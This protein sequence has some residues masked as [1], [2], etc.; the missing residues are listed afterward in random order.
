MAPKKTEVTIGGRSLAFSN[1][2][3]V[4]WPRDGYTKGQL[5]EYYRGVARWIIP[6]LRNRP[7]TLQRWPDGIDGQS[8]FEKQAPRFTPDWIPTVSLSAD[9]RS[10]EIA[11]LLCNDEATLAWCANL[12]AIVLH[13]WYSHVPSID[14][15]DYV[16][17]DL[18]TCEK[19]TLGTLAR[20]TLEFRELL[21][22][23][24][25][26]S[27]VKTSG[28]SGF[29]L[30]VPLQNQYDFEA[31]RR[32]AEIAVQHV[33]AALP[34]LTTVERSI[35][36]RPNTAV[37]LDWGQVGRGKTVVPPYVLRAHDGA[38]VSMPLAWPEVEE[39]V[40][41]RGSPQAF[42]GRWTLSNAR[43]RLEKLGDLWGG[44]YWKPAKLEPA[45]VKARRAWASGQS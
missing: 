4:L 36:K 13:V 39:L 25:L 15:P 21:A 44:R 41:K 28:A 22:E 7:L 33:A 43:E 24:G 27:L 29:H 45:L 42:A 32:F 16:L 10:R 20:V 6:H 30:V 14:S 23:I 5:V 26:P 37:Y 38:P 12:A 19:T 3:K 18:D 8:F 34:E 17:F 35:R 9:R 1:L 2:D 40:K 31:A 11:Y